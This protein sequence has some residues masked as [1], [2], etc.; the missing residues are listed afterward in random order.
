MPEPFIAMRTMRDLLDRNAHLHGAEPHL[1]FAGAGRQGVP[2]EAAELIAHCRQF[3][4]GYKCPKSIDFVTEL[5]R[6]PSGKINK[7][8]LR[9]RY[10][11]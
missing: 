11:L 1:K 4:A 3:I 10:A 8:N 5:P 2:I 6:L 9:S 7:V